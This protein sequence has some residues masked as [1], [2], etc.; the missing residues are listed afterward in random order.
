[1]LNE[2]LCQESRELH[3]EESS[4]VIKGFLLHLISIYYVHLIQT[5]VSL[6]LQLEKL[7]FQIKY[8]KFLPLNHC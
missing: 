3:P 4:I 2:N 7:C 1:M 8:D 6:D 5:P